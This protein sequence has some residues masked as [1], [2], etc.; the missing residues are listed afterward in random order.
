MILDF[1]E[2]P[3]AN[4][5][6]GEQDKFEL[7]ARE[8]LAYMEYNIVEDPS[9]GA[10]GGKDFVVEELFTQKDGS[11]QTIKWLV[12]CKHY[13]HSGKSISD[14]DELNVGD[15]VKQHQCDGFMGFYSTLPS[16]GLSQ[17]LHNVCKAT[18]YDSEK[19]ERFIINS[20][21]NPQA[22][23]LFV[24]FFPISWKKYLSL[25]N[26][27]VLV[28]DI[29]RT[30]VTKQVNDNKPLFDAKIKCDICG[31]NLFEV[32]RKSIYVL[33]VGEKDKIIDVKY[34][35]KG[36]CDMVSSQQ[37]RKN[38]NVDYWGEFS[39]L[40]SPNTW[41]S[42]LVGFIKDVNQGKYTENAFKKMLNLFMQTYAYVARQPSAQEQARYNTLKE[43][44]LI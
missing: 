18:I 27:Q 19:I 14:T 40:L 41:M 1:K 29:K 24:R 22:L 21:N 38:G 15:R 5:A 3:Q 25:T 30:F 4:K 32:P 9:R 16:S 6:T 20:N 37:I 42:E 28:N 26:E 11:L 10:D 31:K 17:R 12:S 43:F 8:F 13:A 39:D 36:E 35:T 34:L 7:F 33:V 44:G 2:I 23:S